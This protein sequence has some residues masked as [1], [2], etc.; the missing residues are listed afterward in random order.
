MQHIPY[1]GGSPATMAVL[2]G[3]V[4]M[5]LAGSLAVLPLI[6]SGGLKPLAIAAR[7]ARRRAA[8]RADVSRAG[9]RLS[10]RHLVRPAG[11]G[12]N[13]ARDRR[14]AQPRD[15]G[16]VA[17]RA[18]RARLAEQGA[19][20]VGGSPQDFAKFLREETER[21]SAVIKRANIQLD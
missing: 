14:H 20:V 13:A 9:H 2:R 5:L 4:Q 6:Q 12:E 3:E 18:V 10:H 7:D 11:A 17:Q 16:R 8:R 1:G 19:D 15:R 21:L